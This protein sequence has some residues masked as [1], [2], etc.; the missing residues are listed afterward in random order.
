MAG[1][2]LTPVDEAVALLLNQAKP[3][4]DT[5]TISL[6]QALHRVLAQ[7][8][9]V[10]ADVPPADNSAV[11]GYAVR[12]ADLAAGRP[13]PVAARI[14][15]GQAPAPLTAG[16]AARIFTGSE[17][18]AGADAVI[19][20]EQAILDDGALATTDTPSPGQNI[21]RR[22]QDLRRGDT[23][24][25][26]GTRLRPQELGLIGSM[27]IAQ[28]MVTRRLRVA[29]LT[30]G[31]ELVEP[32]Q[33]LAAGQIY[34]SNRF[35]L[36]GLLAEAGCDV[37]RC[38]RVADSRTQTEQ[39][40]TQAAKDADLIITSGGVSV[41]EEDHVRAVL[42]QQGDLTLWR[43]A[44]KPGKPLAF[45]R[46][47]DTPLLGLPGNP[48]AVLVTGLIVALPYIQRCQGRLRRPL[49][50]QQLPAGFDAPRPSIR[51]E[52]VRARLEHSDGLTRVAAYPNQSSGMLSSACWADGLA[53]IPEHTAISPGD[54]IT[55]YSFA[56]LLD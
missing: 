2:N 44:I 31:D 38:Q 34:N 6:Q 20:Q 11:D 1:I 42:E 5:E 46:I 25:A 4:T 18:P 21:R 47:N 54:T 41:G 49:N 22:G 29:V 23:S 9:R 40:L 45:G 30:T 17:V 37:V 3:L 16:T 14:A 26:R 12:L 15:A 28:V 35:T 32:G 43:L 10:P 48:A 53:V 33:P 7:D 55:Y 27:G 8:I 19:M 51:R 50:G 13:L 52:Y 36:L 24:L 56:D 39:A